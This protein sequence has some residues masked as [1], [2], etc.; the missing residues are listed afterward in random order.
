MP[1]NP[2][3]SDGSTFFLCRPI[4]KNLQILREELV[5]STAK[6]RKNL[7]F[8][9]GKETL[10]GK[11]HSEAAQARLGPILRTDI[12]LTDLDQIVESVLKILDVSTKLLLRPHRCVHFGP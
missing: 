1:L 9:L 2:Y 8:S 12:R 11:A 5:E 6:R 7:R 10:G 4:L 3:F